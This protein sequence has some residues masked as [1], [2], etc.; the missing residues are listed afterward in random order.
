MADPLSIGCSVI[1]L[2]TFA[3]STSVQLS[4]TLR[5]IQGH[6]KKT[7]ALL[8]EL[9]A[10][11]DVLESVLQTINNSPNVDFDPLRPPLQ[12][13]GEA[14]TKYGQLINEFRKYSTPTHSSLRD[15]LKQRYHWGDVAEFREMI[16]AYKATISIAI[17]NV[18]M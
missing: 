4:N 3:L 11:A 17:A 9:S 13:C 10:L 8:T 12:Q 15:W 18:N 6:T 5:D 2:V 1:A 16:A 14:C 7:R